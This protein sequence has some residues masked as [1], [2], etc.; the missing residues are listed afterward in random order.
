MKLVQNVGFKAHLMLGEVVF[1]SWIQTVPDQLYP[2]S[3]SRL[4]CEELR[5]LGW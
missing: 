3:G 5:A 2:D 1:K 4:D